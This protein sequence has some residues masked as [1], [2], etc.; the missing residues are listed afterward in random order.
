[1]GRGYV[2]R[3]LLRRASTFG[4]LIGIRHSFVHAVVPVVID[5]MGGAYP[6]LIEK[7][8]IIL[9]T[10]RREEERF[11]ATLEQGMRLLESAFAAASA[12][13]IPGEEAFRLYDTFGFPLELTREMAAER[14]LSVDEAGFERA[15]EAQRLRGQAGASTYAEEGALGLDI[16]TQF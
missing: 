11:E 3:R 14:G 1:E 6:E 13:V 7:R 5:Q 12:G 9:K 15:M 16:A 4:R 10:V 2:L 8:D